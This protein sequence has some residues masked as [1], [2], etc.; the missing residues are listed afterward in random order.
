MFNRV[1]VKS[2]KQWFEP[3]WK[4]IELECELYEQQQQKVPL[5]NKIKKPVH[6]CNIWLFIVQAA[7]SL[8]WVSSVPELWCIAHTHARTRQKP[9]SHKMFAVS[10]SKQIMK[11]HSNK[12][13][14][15]LSSSF[16][17]KSQHNKQQTQF[18]QLINHRKISHFS[19][20]LSIFVF[21]MC[22]F[23]SFN[24]FDGT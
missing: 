23:W 18:T 16:V 1:L 7:G 8:Q 22:L 10:Y 21:G 20:S 15:F 14:P 12:Q 24:L 6:H 3:D 5:W 13:A 4:L 2:H 19:F 17:E 11:L 9:E